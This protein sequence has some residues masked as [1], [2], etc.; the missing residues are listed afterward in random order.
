MKC[1]I[2]DMTMDVV[3]IESMQT[4]DTHTINGEPCN[5]Q[6]VHEEV[7]TVHSCL[8]GCMFHAVEAKSYCEEVKGLE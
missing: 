5:I 2:H 7:K 3:S 1:P 4:V 6:S 8:F